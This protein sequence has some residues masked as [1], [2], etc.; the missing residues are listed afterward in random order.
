[1]KKKRWG[2]SCG[3][4]HKDKK[5]TIVKCS[6]ENKLTCIMLVNRIVVCECNRGK[7]TH[8]DSHW[9]VTHL[10]SCLMSWFK[11]SCRGVCSFSKGMTTNIGD[12]LH[13]I[14]RFSKA[15]TTS[16]KQTFL[17]VQLWTDRSS[18][19]FSILISRFWILTFLFL[20]HLNKKI[21]TN[22]TF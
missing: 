16:R 21:E 11:A 9:S 6:T 14:T 1:M 4:K 22:V 12:G 7:Q 15:V 5:I 20:C 17:L 19:R 13:S 18:A 2:L 10:C 8:N 3:G